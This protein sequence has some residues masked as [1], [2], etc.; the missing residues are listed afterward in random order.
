MLCDP[1]K[2]GTGRGFSRMNGSVADGSYRWRS[3][4]EER[5]F[6]Q[7]EGHV[8]VGIDGKIDAGLCKM[9]RVNSNIGEKTRNKILSCQLKN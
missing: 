2:G 6:Y 7:Y 3:R 1:G 8:I 9:A 4:K 5:L